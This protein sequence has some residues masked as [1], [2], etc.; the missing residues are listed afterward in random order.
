MRTNLFIVLV[1]L[2]PVLC[3]QDTLVQVRAPHA[4]TTG[5]AFEVTWTIHG[6]VDSIVRPAMVDVIV[7]SGP[8]ERTNLMMK[9]HIATHTKQFSYTV[10]AR[11]PGTIELPIVRARIDG[12]WHDSPA[13]KIKVI[14]PEQTW[15]VN[16]GKSYAMTERIALPDGTISVHVGEDAGFIN[17]KRKG[18]VVFVRHLTHGEAHALRKKIK[19]LI[20]N[21]R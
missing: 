11:K 2:Q 1:L 21:D 7:I 8:S 19:R 6:Q 16:K 5:D 13:Y 12:Q 15:P 14:G 10:K 17:I 18:D 9:D 20:A 4:L 3:A